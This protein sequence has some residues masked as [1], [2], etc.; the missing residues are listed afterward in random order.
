MS[1]FLLTYAPHA[2]SF[3]PQGLVGRDAKS[4]RQMATPE[5]LTHQLS[6]RFDY[7]SYDRSLE[8]HQDLMC[9]DNFIP[10]R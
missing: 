9:S 4:G 7:E 2:P 6:S 8:S 10:T 1:Q 5:S 3:S